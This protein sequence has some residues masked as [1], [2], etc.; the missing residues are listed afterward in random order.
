LTRDTPHF[1]PG[2]VSTVTHLPTGQKYQRLPGGK[3]VFNEPNANGRKNPMVYKYDPVEHYQKAVDADNR[4]LTAAKNM[5][6]DNLGKITQSL[7]FNQER[8]GNARAAAATPSPE[9]NEQDVLGYLKTLGPGAE[10]SGSG[11]HIN[12]AGE[13]DFYLDPQSSAAKQ[14]NPTFFNIGDTGF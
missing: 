9:Q 6:A 2:K 11:A 3:P 4:A 8:L 12:S 7:E 14:E 1:W 5:G 10:L 13:L